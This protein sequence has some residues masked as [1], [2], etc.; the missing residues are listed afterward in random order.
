MFEPEILWGLWVRNWKM[1]PVWYC[2][3]RWQ[4]TVYVKGLWD[5]KNLR[6]IKNGVPENSYVSNLKINWDNFSATFDFTDEYDEEYVN[7]ATFPLDGSRIIPYT[8]PGDHAYG[9]CLCDMCEATHQC[10]YK[11]CTNTIYYRDG[12]CYCRDCGKKTCDN[13]ATVIEPEEGLKDTG[14]YNVH[15]DGTRVCTACLHAEEPQ[16]GATEIIV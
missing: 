13:H 1:S 16:W 9:N 3:R 15:Q 4:S 11:G 5:G 12:N 10:D 6:L 7:R 14:F 8:T 2:S